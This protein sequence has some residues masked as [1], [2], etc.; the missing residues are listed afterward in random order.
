MPS[1]QTLEKIMSYIHNW[2]VY[3][4]TV[5]EWEIVGNS[6][7][8]PFLQDGQFFRVVGSVF[9]DGLHQY[10]A[11]DLQDETF[12]GG[13]W[14]LAIPRDFIALAE[15]IEEWESKYGTAASSPFASESF[16]NYS[17]SKGADAKANSAD[18]ATGWQRI[19][20]ARL[21]AYRKLA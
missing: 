14:G 8:L 2:F 9:N 4:I 16:E 1:I 21:N 13:I 15:E 20:M 12:K 7:D 10:P 18:P 17:Y 6:L 11:D 19:F 3:Q 5:D